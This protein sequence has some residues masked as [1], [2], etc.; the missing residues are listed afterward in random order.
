[1]KIQ[2]SDRFQHWIKTNKYLIGFIIL[3]SI[4]LVVIGSWKISPF[5]ILNFVPGSI[6]IIGII[7]AL[8]TK[9]RGAILLAG[10]AL[11]AWIALIS[12]LSVISHKEFEPYFFSIA[13]ICTLISAFL[14]FFGVKIYIRSPKG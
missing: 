5:F 7:W 1:M 11:L 6:L 2:T 10:G 3:L 12:W 8:Y 4:A 9:K 14:I 13:V